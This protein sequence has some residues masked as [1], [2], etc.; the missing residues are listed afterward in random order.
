MESTT[1]EI[2]NAVRPPAVARGAQ[3][4]AAALAIGLFRSI[5]NLAQN[6][7]G[8][9]MIFALLIVIAFFGLLFFVVMQISA[10]KNWARILVLIIVLVLI[11]FLPFSIPAYLQE[12]R[13]SVLLGALGII[14]TLLQLVGTALL[15]TRQSNL[16]FRTRK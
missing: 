2:D 4:L 8:V 11:L 15:F 13:R 10:G 7:S 5:L 12:L 1:D 14:I 16:W 6:S 9:T 3:L